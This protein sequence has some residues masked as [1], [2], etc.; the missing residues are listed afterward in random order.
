MG[1]GLSSP[2]VARRAANRHFT[3]GYGRAEDLAGAIVLIFVL[4]S[5]GVAVY[6]SYVKLISRS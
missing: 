2:A 5:A 4:F 6:E 3:Y 1:T